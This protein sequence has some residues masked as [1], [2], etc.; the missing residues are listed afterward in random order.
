MMNATHIIH[1]FLK[2]TIQF[3]SSCMIGAKKK[4]TAYQKRIPQKKEY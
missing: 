1:K 4:G 2:S 3:T